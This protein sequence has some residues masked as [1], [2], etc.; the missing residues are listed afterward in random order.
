MVIK[1]DWTK[2]LYHRS[3]IKK[4]LVLA[5]VKRMF[6]SDQI[7]E[8]INQLEAKWSSSSTE[9]S[10]QQIG[11]DITL[12]LKDIDPVAY[13]RFASVYLNFDGLDDFQQLLQW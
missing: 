9:I 7:E 11:Q 12:M 10:S 5:F 2:E 1:K 8:L 6:G 4:A 3:K 13:V